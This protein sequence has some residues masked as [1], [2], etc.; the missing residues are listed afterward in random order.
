VKHDRVYASAPYGALHVHRW[1]PHGTPTRSPLVCL[2]PNPYSGRYFSTIAPLLAAER[3]VIAPDY[4]GCG[5]SDPH[6]GTPSIEDY[7]TA[8]DAALDQ[9]GLQGETVDVMGFHTGALVAVQLALQRAASFGRLVLIDVPF[10]TDAELEQRR[11]TVAADPLYAADGAAVKK[12]WDFSVTE[13]IA[14]MSFA[15]AFENFIDQ[16]RAGSLANQVYRAVYRY[17]CR[18][19]L[20]LIQF[21]TLMIATNGILREPTRRAAM[22]VSVARVL[23]LD[24]V[25][26]AALD[27]GA[28]PIAAA[29][30][31]F[32]DTAIA[33]PPHNAQ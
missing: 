13:R 3:I 2:H 32:L 24:D 19:R 7:A 15:R 28:R 10:F 33:A 5:A 31:D 26:H 11:V 9:L 25:T 6:P 29:M 22:L 14:H 1:S 18:E 16:L 8:I 27:A 4:P 23:D 30:L 21:P 17:P 20:P 12:A